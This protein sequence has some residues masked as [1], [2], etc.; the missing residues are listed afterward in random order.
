MNGLRF[1]VGELAII[2]VDIDGHGY[3]G[4]IVEILEVGPLLAMNTRREVKCYDYETSSLSD[5]SDRGLCWDIELRK[6]DQRGEPTSLVRE[7]DCEVA[8]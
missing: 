4:S 5:A 6:L 1:K 3:E 8:A 2:A 7:S